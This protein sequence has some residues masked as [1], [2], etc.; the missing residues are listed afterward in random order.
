MAIISTTWGTVET[1]SDGEKLP[2]STKELKCEIFPQFIHSPNGRF[3][4]GDGE[5]IIYT[6]LGLR[7]KSFGQ[8]LGV[9]LVLDSNEYAIFVSRLRALN[10]SNPSRKN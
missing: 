5:Y 10:S 3:K 6:A 7:N 8:A 4:C 2:L 1:P 9:C